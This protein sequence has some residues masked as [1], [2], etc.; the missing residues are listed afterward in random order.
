MKKFLIIIPARKG[1][2]RIRNKNIINV[3]GR[4]LIYYTIKV[5]LRLKK[6]RLVDEVIVSTDSK[7]IAKIAQQFGAAVPFLR[8]KRISGDKAKSVDF[9][10]HAINYFER[11]K[12]FF[13]AVIILQPTS[14]LRKYKDVKNAIEI[15]LRHKNDSLISVYREEKIKDSYMYYKKGDLAV[16]LKPNHNKGLRRQDLKDIYIRNGAIYISAVK[17]VKKSHKIISP[18]PLLYEM[19]KDR[20][21]N[22]D[23]PEDLKTLRKILCK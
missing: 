8:P 10:L 14:P 18:K 5:A 9:V 15:Y 6:N 16:P 12:I 21:L 17:Y 11:K 7:K 22:I 23:E 13:D 20:S 1:S 2:K 4:P 19:P 3:C